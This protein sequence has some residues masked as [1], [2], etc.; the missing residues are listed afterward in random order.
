NC[1]A[2]EA[3]RTPL[4]T[5]VLETPC[6]LTANRSANSARDFL[7]PCV[8]TLAMLLAVTLRSAEAALRPLSAR[9]N[10]MELSLRLRFYLEDIGKR[11]VAER[12]GGEHGAAAAADD[13]AVD[14]RADEHFALHGLAALGEAGG[15][16]VFA[17]R[18]ALAIQRAAVPVEIDEAVA[19]DGNPRH[20]RAGGVLDLDG[21]IADAAVDHHRAAHALAVEVRAGG[22]HQHFAADEPRGLQGLVGD[23]RTRQR[24]DRGLHL[25]DAGDR[26]ELRQLAEELAVLH[27]LERVLVAE[28]RDHQREEVLLPQ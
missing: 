13:D 9:L 10:G 25:L 3:R 2:T 24:G 21:G 19:F 27:R 8:L 12:L 22:R 28:L 17:G 5:A 23:Q 18:R 16:P 11:D 7:K 14:A 1:C 4:P 6:M 26:A 20:Q 15:D